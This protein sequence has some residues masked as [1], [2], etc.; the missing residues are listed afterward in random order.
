[1][2]IFISKLNL[3]LKDCLLSWIE[4]KYK[5]KKKFKYKKSSFFLFIQTEN[6]YIHASSIEKMIFY[7]FFIFFNYYLLNLVI[8]FVHELIFNCSIVSLFWF[9]YIFIILKNI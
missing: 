4:I 3:I 7:N 2:P 9:F 6:L 8:E 5:K 1:M